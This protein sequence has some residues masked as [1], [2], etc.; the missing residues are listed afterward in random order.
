MTFRAKSLLGGATGLALTAGLLVTMGTQAR[1]DVVIDGIDIPAGATLTAQVVDETL[2]T[3]TGQSLVAVGIVSSI[4]NSSL[5]QTYGYGQGGKYLTF[6]ITGFTASYI[7]PPSPGSTGYVEFTG[8]TAN[9]YVENSAPDL[10]TGNQS[11]DLA[12]ASS[13]TLFLNLTPQ[14]FATNPT[15]QG[16]G[17]PTTTT[18]EAIIPNNSTLSNFSNAFGSATLDATG[19][20]AANNFHTCTF[21][22]DPLA[23]A[24]CP[25]GTTD[26]TFTESFSSTASGDF[27]VSGTGN[28][29][30]SLV[31]EPASMALL[32]SALIGLGGI[33]WR[34]RRKAS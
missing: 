31:P 20:D 14:I 34:R 4:V 6:T 2:I 10:A 15:V 12:N 11:T 29:K 21:S 9:A 17:G 22:V 18:L 32:G 5:V 27:P 24:P 1:A 23:G 25:S 7:L 30:A 28:L 13:G 16:A 19:G 3:A 8:G 26:V 33:S